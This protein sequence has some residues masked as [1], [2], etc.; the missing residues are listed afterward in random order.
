VTTA[1]VAPVV[2]SAPT[3]VVRQRPAAAKPK[4]KPKPK[5]RVT[6]RPPADVKAP[7]VTLRRT[8]DALSVRI[9]KVG[10]TVPAPRDGE[11]LLLAA[12]ALV[13]LAAASGGF[14]GL[15]QHYRRQL[16]V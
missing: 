7:P 8:P 6:S 12:L 3:R 15:Y 4:P 5:P 2:Q 9:G 10:V 16:G 13:V 11:A 1:S 14:L